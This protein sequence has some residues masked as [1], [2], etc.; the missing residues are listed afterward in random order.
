MNKILRLSLVAILTL[1][2]GAG[3]AQTTFDFA[4]LY[5]S[6]TIGDITKM[7]QTVD[8]IT[9]SFAKGNSQNNPAYNKAGEVR[10]YGGTGADVLDGCTMTFT[11]TSGNIKNITLEHGTIDNGA[12]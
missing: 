9:V 11:S 3:F 8:G 7:P 10:L 5:G 6:A 1:I 4:A 12:F 2:C